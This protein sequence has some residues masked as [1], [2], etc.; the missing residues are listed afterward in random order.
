MARRDQPRQSYRGTAQHT[1]V[2]RDRFAPWA[3]TYT[4]SGASGVFRQERQRLF[5]HQEARSGT[6][7]GILL[8]LLKCEVGAAMRRSAGPSSDET[9]KHD[10]LTTAATPHLPGLDGLR[11][12][13][14]ILVMGVHFLGGA[15]ADTPLQ[16]LLVRIATQGWIGV[17]L[18]FVLSGFLITGLLVDSKGT[19]H[20]FR[21]FYARRTLRIFPLYY[22]VLACFFLLLPQLATLS[23]LLEAAKAHQVWLWTYTSNFFIAHTS[24]WE[25]LSYFSHF[26]SLAIEEQ[27][28]LLWPLVVFSLSSSTLERVCIAV[29]VVALILRMA[30]TLLGV[31]A[32]SISVL[33]P[34]RIDTLCVGAYLALRIRRP[35]EHRVW[36]EASGRVA[37]ALAAAILVVIAFSSVMHLAAPILHQIRNSL[38]ALLF[39]ALVLV[40]IRPNADAVSRLFQGR[41]L[42]FFGKYSYGLYVYHGLLTWY[43]VETRFEAQ[44]HAYLGDRYLTMLGMVTVGVTASLVVAVASYELFERRFLTLKRY[45]ET[46]P[47]PSLVDA[48]GQ[49]PVMRTAR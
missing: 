19:S 20:F 44:L 5:T 48:S 17:D 33:T 37:L 41:F 25:S 10:G 38:Y 11:G 9:K 28:Y 4:A 18:F 36:V 2:M 45:F 21:N 3:L 26:W 27:F 8:I 12:V 40:A 15:Q 43:F 39:G 16:G 30:L 13:A 42:R 31:S 29:V 35:G 32:L 24:S 14:V 46:T 47:G 7:S 1:S 49:P 22:F 6:R 23:P 34:C